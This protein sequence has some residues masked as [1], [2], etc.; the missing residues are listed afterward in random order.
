MTTI[1]LLR[2]LRAMTVLEEISSG[3]LTRTDLDDLG[4]RDAGAWE[5]LSAIYHGP[6]RHPHLQ[7][8][9]RHAAA[10]LSLD[11][12]MTIEKH[13]RKLLPGAAVT[14]W[15]LRV[16]LCRLR[17]TVAEID[18]EAAAR[19]RS[20]NRAVAD[21]EQKA[22]GKRALRGGKN[23][24][25]QGLRTFTVTGPERAV[26]GLLGQVRAGAAHL[27]RHNPQLTYEQAMYDSF[28]ASQG[29]GGAGATAPIPYVVVPLPEWAKVLHHQGDETVFGLTDGTTMTGK[30]LLEQVTAEYHVAGIYDPVAG[31]VNAYRS[32]RTASP[33]QRMMLITESLTC[34]AMCDTAADECEIH[35]LIAWKNGGRTN[36]AEMT[37]LCRKHNARNDDDPDQ[38]PRHGRVER[39]PGGVLF[40]PPDGSPPKANPHPLRAYSARGLAGTP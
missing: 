19:V 12:V 17:G 4:Y 31:P 36:V 34:E 24:D 27:R 10:A 7:T 38:P 9:A 5:K 25:A 8:T 23:T 20:Y 15:E 3:A 32:E 22:H 16:E 40:H 28:M 2:S 37:V 29:G 1:E 11:A 14:E 21:A 35:H 39:H 30:E 26:T 13:T 18:H 33:K 6:T